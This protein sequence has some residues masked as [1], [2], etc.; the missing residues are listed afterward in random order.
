MK[1]LDLAV[2]AKHVGSRYPAPF[3]E[4]CKQRQTQR[5]GDAAGLT[6]FGVNIVRLPPGAWSGQRHWHTHE[7]EFVYVLEGEA[8][9]S[10]DAGDE[11]MKPG[12]AAGFKAGDTNGHCFKNP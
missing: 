11:V 7:D 6:A 4:Q 2:I 3:D 12:D 8:I 5:I 9:L 1:K 10:T